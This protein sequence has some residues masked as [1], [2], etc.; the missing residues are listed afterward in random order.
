MK[1]RKRQLPSPPSAV[2][3]E[4]YIILSDPVSPVDMPRDIAVGHKKKGLPRLEKTVQKEEE[5]TSPSRDI[6]RK[7][8]RFSSYP[9]S[10]SHF[11]DFEAPCHGEAISEHVWK[12]AITEEYQY[13]LKNDV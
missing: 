1:R 6:L 9:S 10:M 5:H 8:K 4:T 12:D 2:H 11:I 7:Q 3:R 13:I